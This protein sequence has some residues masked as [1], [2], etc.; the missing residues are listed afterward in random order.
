[1][2]RHIVRT[3]MNIAMVMGHHGVGLLVF[4]AKILEMENEDVGYRGHAKDNGW[5]MLSSA[6][7]DGAF[8]VGYCNC[9]DLIYHGLSPT[10]GMVRIS[11]TKDALKNKWRADYMR[12]QS[13][14][15]GDGQVDAQDEEFVTLM[16]ETHGSVLIVRTTQQFGDLKKFWKSKIMP[17]FTKSVKLH[18]EST[19]KVVINGEELDTT[20][21]PFCNPAENIK[22]T[23]C[24]TGNG[25]WKAVGLEHFGVPCDPRDEAM[26]EKLLQKSSVKFSEEMFYDEFIPDGAKVTLTTSFRVGDEKRAKEELVVDPY[27]GHKF[28]SMGSLMHAEG[29]MLGIKNGKVTTLLGGVTTCE[30]AVKD[31]QYY[32]RK[33]YKHNLKPHPSQLTFPMGSVEQLH[34]SFFECDV[35]L[36]TAMDVYIVKQKSELLKKGKGLQVKRAVFGIKKLM[37]KYMASAI[38]SQ[39]SSERG[40]ATPVRRSERPLPS[41]SSSSSSPLSSSSSSSS[42]SPATAS[43]RA[44]ASRAN[45]SSRAKSASS[46][47]KSA[48][49][50]ATASRATASRANASRANASRANAS[51]PVQQRKSSRKRGVPLT[52]T[53]AGECAQSGGNRCR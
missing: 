31:C 49:S 52:P 50:R 12:Y 53:R 41:A 15:I 10:V 18:G 48:S 11:E 27:T 17:S 32:D 19:I 39:A 45:A 36:K 2:I 6:K 7:N 22:M 20:H 24:H 30:S 28:E 42:S 38:P 4:L 47:A 51:S 37:I 44:T 8:V 14:H 43:S 23:L 5:A 3:V 33:N 1:M 25:V 34:L 35:W 13:E 40:N 46:R 21:K 29:L 16:R 9:E 26:R